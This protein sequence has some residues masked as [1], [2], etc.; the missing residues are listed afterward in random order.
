MSPHKRIIGI[1]LPILTLVHTHETRPFN[2]AVGMCARFA[3]K[4][5]VAATIIGI[6]SLPLFIKKE[7]IKDTKTMNKKAF[8][9]QLIK[10][11]LG[12]MGTTAAFDYF[13]RAKNEEEAILEEQTLIENDELPKVINVSDKKLS[14]KEMGEDLRNTANTVA[15]VG[16]LVAVGSKVVFWPFNHWPF[17]RSKK[18]DSSEPKYSSDQSSP[19]PVQVGIDPTFVNQAKDLRRQFDELKEQLVNPATSQNRANISDEDCQELTNKFQQMLETWFEEKNDLLAYLGDIYQGLKEGGSIPENLK[20][21]EDIQKIM[22]FMGE[23]VRQQLYDQHASVAEYLE[24]HRKKVDQDIR[25]KVKQWDTQ[26]RTTRESTQN[27]LAGL[28]S[29]LQDLE[30]FQKNAALILER[31]EKDQHEANSLYAGN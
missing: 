12:G 27:T 15:A 4:S 19:I 31:S 18:T 8:Y 29:K 2:S 13:A 30:N 16:T 10:I 1:L 24:E 5:L 11:I 25:T 17:K 7:D 23:M 14:T 22:T 28:Q 20:N 26:N 6:I 21:Q 3:G 9:E